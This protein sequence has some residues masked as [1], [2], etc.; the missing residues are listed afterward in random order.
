MANTND[1]PQFETAITRLEEI[2]NRLE[3]ENL[4]L[5]E[6]LE[7]FKEGIQL[8]KFCENKLKNIEQQIEVVE[9]SDYVEPEP[10]ASETEPVKKSK[11]SKKTDNEDQGSLF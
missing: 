7:V 5:D 2:T 9:N 8:T 11:K 3:N 6:A 10:Q 4:T 1:E